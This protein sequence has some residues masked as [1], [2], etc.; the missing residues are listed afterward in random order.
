L[1]PNEI[2]PNKNIIMAYSFNVNETININEFG[3]YKRDKSYIKTNKD[4]NSM[5]NFIINP[6]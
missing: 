3:L 2:P 1:N 6:D 4:I 5:F